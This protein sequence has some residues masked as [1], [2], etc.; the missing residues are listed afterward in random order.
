MFLERISRP[1]AAQA[2]LAASQAVHALPG[3]EGHHVVIDIDDPVV[4]SEQDRA[5]VAEVDAYLAKH[6]DT[7]FLV[8]TVANTI[9]PQATCA[10]QGW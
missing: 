6:S 2:W 1:S 7:G 3:H 8:R 9:F 5:I 10:F 4:E